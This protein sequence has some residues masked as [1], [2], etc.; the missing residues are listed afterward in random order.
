MGD[1]QNLVGNRLKLSIQT[2]TS[3]YDVRIQVQIT[4]FAVRAI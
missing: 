4:A 3:A 2:M 1:F